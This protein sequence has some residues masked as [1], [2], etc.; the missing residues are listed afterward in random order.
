M[1][2]ESN[3]LIIRTTRFISELRVEDILTGRRF[4]GEF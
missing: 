4:R 2:N 1:G 3:L